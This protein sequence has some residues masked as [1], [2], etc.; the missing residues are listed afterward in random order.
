VNNI[1]A[2]L[3]ALFC[4]KYGMLIQAKTKKIS[5]GIPISIHTAMY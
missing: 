2:D 5:P 4:A 3:R 1:I